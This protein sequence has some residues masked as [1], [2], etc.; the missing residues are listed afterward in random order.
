ML[1]EVNIWLNMD[2]FVVFVSE[3]TIPISIQ[4]CPSMY[5][6]Y[7][8]SF[9]ICYIIKRICQANY[10]KNNYSTD[11][12]KSWIELE[13][14]SF[15]SLRNSKLTWYATFLL[16]RIIANEMPFVSIIINKLKRK[17]RFS[18]KLANLDKDSFDL[19][20]ILIYNYKYTKFPDTWIELIQTRTRP[21]WIKNSR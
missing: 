20:V 1:A 9:L 13:V 14:V 2:K 12:S 17:K 11:S 16:G 21:N 18:S 15:R 10:E 19:D 8:Y 3:L 4:N 5:V 7:L 6:I